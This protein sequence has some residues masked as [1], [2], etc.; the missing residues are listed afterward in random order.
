MPRKRTRLI[1]DTSGATPKDK[2]QDKKIR[3]LERKVLTGEQKYIAQFRTSV[4][5]TTT[6]SELATNN[7]FGATGQ[8]SGHNSREGL[9]IQLKHINVKILIDVPAS[10]SDSTLTNNEPLQFRLVLFVNKNAHGLVTNF[11]D[12]FE[13]GTTQLLRHRNRTN[14]DFVFLHD[15]LYTMPQHN[16]AVYDNGG[17]PN[18]AYARQRKYIELK[19]SF[20]KPLLIQATGSTAGISNYQNNIVGLGISANLTAPTLTYEARMIFDDN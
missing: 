15:K 7:N 12:M 17:T 13:T 3:R 9:N 14:R 6:W 2:Q 11:D 4:P 10:D 8:G 19:H 1:V 18:L 20:K 5:M 16:I